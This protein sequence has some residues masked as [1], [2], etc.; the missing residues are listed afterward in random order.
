MPDSD[1][2]K[3]DPLP[4][5]DEAAAAGALTVLAF[6]G[7]WLYWSLYGG[8]RHLTQKVERGWVVR[9]VTANGVVNPTATA[10]VGARVSGMIRARHGADRIHC[11]CCGRWSLMP[12]AEASRANGRR[13]G[14]PKEVVSKA[15]YEVRKAVRKD[16]RELCQRNEERHVAELERIAQFSPNDNARISAISLLFDR[17]R[18]KAAQPHT[19]EGVWEQ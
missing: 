3:G 5:S 10:P 7:G 12:S 18:G 17:R 15:E 1:R 19:G 2:P 6:G 4:S 9:I 8:V 16:L 14:R 13:G 11:A